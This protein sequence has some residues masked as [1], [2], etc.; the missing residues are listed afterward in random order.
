MICTHVNSDVDK[1]EK[2]NPLKD[3]TPEVSSLLSYLCRVSAVTKYI[4]IFYPFAQ[5]E[6]GL[7][8]VKIVFAEKKKQILNHLQTLI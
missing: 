4:Y 7:C 8:D 1:A 6:I 3:V 5:A 2:R